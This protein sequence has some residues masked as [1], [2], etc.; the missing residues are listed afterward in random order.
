MVRFWSK[1][2]EQTRVLS[3]LKHSAIASCLG[4]LDHSYFKYDTIFASY[5]YWIYSGTPCKSH[6]DRPLRLYLLLKQSLREFTIVCIISH[7]GEGK[8]K[9]LRIS[10]SLQKIGREQ[11]RY[12]HSPP[13]HKLWTLSNLFQTFQFLL[14]LYRSFPFNSCATGLLQTML[15]ESILG[16]NNQTTLNMH[17]TADI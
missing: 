15:E 2:F 1:C 7:K 11:F 4:Y 17:M 16:V 6:R 13:Q 9:S 5:P 8:R 12:Q 10:R 14:Q 3:G